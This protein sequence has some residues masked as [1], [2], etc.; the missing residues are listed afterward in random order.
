MLLSSAFCDI[1]VINLIVAPA[2]KDYSDAR[3]VIS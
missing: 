1:F 2:A 3:W